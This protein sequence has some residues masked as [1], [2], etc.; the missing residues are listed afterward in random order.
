[1]AITDWEKIAIVLSI[2]Q[3]WEISPKVGVIENL[4]HWEEG[5][6]CVGTRI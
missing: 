3:L 4:I 6:Y 1:V 5:I 2:L